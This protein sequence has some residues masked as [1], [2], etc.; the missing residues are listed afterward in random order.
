[1]SNKLVTVIIL[2][3]SILGSTKMQ[4]Q[5]KNLESYLLDYNYESRIDMK[6]NSEQLK[7][8]II[9]DKAILIDIRFKEEYASWNMPFAK[10]IPLNELPNRLDEI[11]KS[12][13]IVTACPHKDRAIIAMVYLQTKGYK[14]KYLTDGLL[15]LADALRG[16]NAYNFHYKL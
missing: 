5:E 8:L 14:V 4:A 10:N 3:L 7:D 9:N 13:I 15:G 12:K 1:M 2:V 6:I 16:G 11:D